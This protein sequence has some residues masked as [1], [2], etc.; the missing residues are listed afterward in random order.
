MDY[1][2]NSYFYGKDSDGIWFGF[3]YFYFEIFWAG[4]RFDFLK[5]KFYFYKFDHDGDGNWKVIR[6]HFF[7][8]AFEMQKDFK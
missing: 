2:E 1:G 5:P 4:L 7:N 3:K 8:I 6:F